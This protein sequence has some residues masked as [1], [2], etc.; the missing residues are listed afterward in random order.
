MRILFLSYWYPLPPDNGSKLRIHNLLRGLAQRHEVTLITFADRP[1]TAQAEARLAS[2][3]REVRVV[4]RK[5]Y[6]TN[7]LGGIAGFF[8]LMP[9]FIKETFSAEMVSQIRRVLERGSFDLVIASQLGTACYQPYFRDVPAIFEEVEIGSY[10]DPLH[11]LPLSRRKIRHALTWLKHRRYLSRLIQEFRGCV[12]V[13]KRERDLISNEIMAGKKPDVIPNFLYLQDYVEVE[14]SPRE[15]SLIFTGSFRYPANHEAMV[16]F[17]SQVYP[18]ILQHIPDVSLMITGDN[19]GLQLPPATNLK[20]TGFVEDVA[21]LVASASLSIV[22]LL[23]GGGTRLKILES[24]ALGTPV[25]STSKGAE[26][27]GAKDGHHLLIA[28]TRE[29]FADYV[30]HLL[31]DKEMRDYLSEQGLQFVKEKYAVEV[32]YPHFE[33]L[34]QKV[35]DN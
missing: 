34:I 20:Q 2:L 12:V 32:V 11:Q 6:R 31:T 7:S 1:P 8:D 28:D 33:D 35:V 17:L 22:P 19:D 26:G 9:R 24:M 14:R 18:L 29:V 21:P 16:W 4:P 10:Y 3:C 15:A 23:S 27:L 25:V 5:S 13:S 30:M